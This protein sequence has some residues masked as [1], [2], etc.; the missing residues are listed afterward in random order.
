[1]H[2]SMGGPEVVRVCCGPGSGRPGVFENKVRVQ[3][4]LVDL[5]VSGHH[6]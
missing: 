2:V 4:P 3:V 1:M 6:V 5:S